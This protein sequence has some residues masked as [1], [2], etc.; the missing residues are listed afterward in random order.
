KSLGDALV[1]YELLSPPVLAELAGAILV[2]AASLPRPVLG[3][4]D[5]SVGILR[6]EGL[7][8]VGTANFQD[9]IDEAFKFVGS[10]QGQMALEDDAVKTG[11]HSNDQ[12]GK[13]GDEARQRLHGVLLWKGARTNPILVWERLPCYSSLVAALPRW[14]RAGNN[15]PVCFRYT[16]RPV[17]RSGAPGGWHGRL[18]AG[19]RAGDDPI[20]QFPGRE[21]SAALRGRRGYETGP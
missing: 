10:C 6:C 4:I 19:D 2:G 20:V 13:L 3:V 15:F 16:I 8:E 12:A 1:A 17:E 7:H 5:Q 18:R 9:V 21:G 11:E 14:D